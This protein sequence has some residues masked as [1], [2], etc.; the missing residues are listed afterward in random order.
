MLVILNWPGLVPPKAILVMDSRAVPVPAL[1]TVTGTGVL[2]V[3]LVVVGKG[4]VSGLTDN[5]GAP[6]KATPVPERATG[7]PVTTT[8]PV[9]VAVPLLVTAAVGLKITP[10]VQVLPAARV[11]PQVPPERENGAVTATVIPVKEAVPVLLR[12]SVWA[13]L[14]DPTVTLPKGNEVGA[15]LAMGAVAVVVPLST[16]VAL[17]AG[18]ATLTVKFVVFAPVV[19][20]LKV[21]LM[22]QLAPTASV[23]GNAVAQLPP[24]RAN[25]PALPP[26]RLMF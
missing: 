25:W 24:E 11:V 26:V 23:A 18:A 6:V 10:M 17:V 13:A 21:T 22:V 19:V 16:T 20:G 4:M 1:L 12:V 7:E 15:T 3:P 2:D 14:V 9:M 5:T 8:L